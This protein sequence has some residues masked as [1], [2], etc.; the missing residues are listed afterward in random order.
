MIR[1]Q[2]DSGVVTELDL[3]RSQ[4]Q[5]D[6][7]KGDMARYTQLVA[8]DQNA[9]NLLAGGAVPEELLPVDLTGVTAPADI[10]PGLSS[11]VLL[12]RPDVMSA[13]HQLKAASAFIDAA[14]AAF[15]PRISLTTTIGTASN[16]LSG[17]F[18]AETA[19]WSFVPQAVLPVFDARIWAAFRVS[20]ATREI[21]L[22]QY[23]KTIQA[24]FR[25]VADTL[26]VRGT[27]DQQIAAQA[28]IVASAEKVYELSEQRYDQGIDSYLGVLDAQ[29]SLYAA[30]Q[31]L[32]YLRLARLANQV[33]LFA[34]LG[35]EG[36]GQN[37]IP[38]VTP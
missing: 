21:A 19:T 8:Q 16:D 20:K 33:R 25:E 32:T 11:S 15:F 35:G 18:N 3:R 5:V 36:A 34:V 37:T 7:A 24:A 12:R 9:L 30:Q 14:R 26:A 22:A 10:A 38:V 4:T 27:V 23:E 31:G 6:V 28:S 13:E 1:K 17:L 29:R 2:Y